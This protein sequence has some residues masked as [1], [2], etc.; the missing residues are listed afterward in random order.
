[1]KKFL[2][3]LVML[4]FLAFTNTS[5]GELVITEQPLE[6]Q[7]VAH[8]DGGAVFSNLCAA[9]HGPGGEGNGRA[10]GALNR[11]VPDLTTLSAKND[12]VY[13][14]S[15]VKSAILGKTRVVEHGTIDMPSWGE[16]FSNVRPSGSALIRQ[17]YARE[18]V[19]LLTRYIQSL[20]G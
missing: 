18:R 17:A 1:M 7:D 14:Y 11:T 5:A 6:W 20:Q 13:P 8:L 2:G 15:R 19:R 4:G 10:V 3:I 12:G 16:Q 9:C